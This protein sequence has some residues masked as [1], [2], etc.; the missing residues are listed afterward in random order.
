[1]LFCYH[2]VWIDG[3]VM[4]SFVTILLIFYRRTPEL[5]QT[6]T[7]EIFRPLGNDDSMLISLD[8]GGQ[9]SLILLL[10]LSTVLFV[11]RIVFN[12]CIK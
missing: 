11:M 1:V 2:F 4:N 6:V 10:D 3:L 8:W 12:L 9:V 5:I 7:R